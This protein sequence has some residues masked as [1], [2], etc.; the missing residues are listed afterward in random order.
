MAGHKITVCLLYT[1]YVLRPQS[2][3]LPAHGS[4]VCQTIL[5]E[6]ISTHMH[7]DMSGW[8]TDTEALV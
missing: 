5:Q 6:K 3:H 8:D 7:R 2:C 4:E 1:V